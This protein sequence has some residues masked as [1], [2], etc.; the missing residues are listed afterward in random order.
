METY[1]ISR[2]KCLSIYAELDV[3]EWNQIKNEL[4]ENNVC[5]ANSVGKFAPLV[6]DGAVVG[7]AS[8]VLTSTYPNVYTKTYPHLK[9]IQSKMTELA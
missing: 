2:D 6:V 1:I 7:V 3:E 5:T 4:T 8:R 9:W